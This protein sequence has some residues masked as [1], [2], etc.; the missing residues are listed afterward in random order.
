M[1]SHSLTHL[2]TTD[3]ISLLSATPSVALSPL[4]Y[5]SS[6][7]LCAVCVPGYLNCTQETT[8]KTKIKGLTEML[9]AVL[10]IESVLTRQSNLMGGCVYV[11]VNV[12]GDVVRSN[13]QRDGMGTRKVQNLFLEDLLI[14]RPHLAR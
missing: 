14:G 7:S 9:L 3:S 13:I 2:K 4:L 6:L 1:L 5:F 10:Q 8:K 12:L 11:C